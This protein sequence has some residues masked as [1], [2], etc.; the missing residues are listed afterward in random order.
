MAAMDIPG[1]LVSDS[2]LVQETFELA[3][4]RGGRVSAGEIAHS[5][6]RLS[7]ADESLASALVADLV[8]NDARFRIDGSAITVVLDDFEN[9]P[10][11]QN[12][13][14]VLDV[15]AAHG[16]SLPPKIIEI[17]AYRVR[18][19][20]IVNEFQTLINP[21]SPVPAFITSLTGITN[22]MVRNA[23][24]FPDVAR[25][26]LRFAGD[27][28]LVAHNT[29]FDLPLLNREIGRVF[30]GHRMRNLD[31]CT[32]KLARRLIPQLDGHN[33]DSLA[34]HFAIPITGRHRADAD[35]HATAQIL[36]RLL[37]RLEEY[38][39]PTLAAARVFSVNDAP[40]QTDDVQLTL[41]V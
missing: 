34:T 21:E 12:E 30:P 5:V 1:N 3:R 31:L 2:S 39:V 19:G 25:E 28:I 6:F 18:S 13:F 4:Q 15:E 40:R 7:H 26:W 41:G 23:P 37:A 17:G 27:A 20:Q 10:L 29:T 9:R 24:T 8:Q 14:V 38:G 32:V 36:I 33:L 22:Q 35:A 16:R 11:N